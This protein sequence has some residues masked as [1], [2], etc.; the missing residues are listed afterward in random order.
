MIQNITVILTSTA[1]LAHAL[2]GCCWHHAHSGESNIEGDCPVHVASHAHSGE[3]DRDLHQHDCDSKSQHADHAPASH[4]SDEGG[5]HRHSVCDEGQ[6]EFVRS[7]K[8]KPPLSVSLLTRD[9]VPLDAGL[10][11]AV[12][13]RRLRPPD[14]DSLL[15]RQLQPVQQLTQAWLL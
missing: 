5:D 4:D 7:S 14:P 6:C 1:M 2:L 15:R 8:I 3:H 9:T 13:T 11:F 10:T 12:L